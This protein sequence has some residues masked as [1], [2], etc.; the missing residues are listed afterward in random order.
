MANMGTK[1]RQL[2]TVDQRRLL[3]KKIAKMS[4]AQR[5]KLLNLAQPRMVEEYMAHIPHPKQQVF[6]TLRAKE[7]MYGGAA[8][9]GKSDALLMAALQYVDVP[10]YSALI[11]RRTWPDLN[12]PG[13][14]LDRASTWFAGTRAHKR[15]G[16]RIWEFPTFDKEGN[17]A[18]PARISF[19]YMLHDKD[20]HK[21]A[22]AEYQYIGFDEL[23]H[24]DEGQ[25]TFLFSRIRRPDLVCLNCSSA[26]RNYGGPS[27][28]HTSKNV[29]CKEPYPDPKVLAQYPP[30]PDGTSVFDVPL[31]MRSATNPGSTG[32]EWVRDRFVNLVTRK[33]DAVFIPASLAD[34]PSLDY[35]A[36]RENLMH[37]SPVERE[38][39]LN[40][41]W[42]V[43]E[44]G[45]MFERH[46]FKMLRSPTPP[47]SRNVVRFWDN[48]ASAGTG[49]WTVGVKM[50]HTDDGKWVIEDVVRGQWSTLQKQQIMAQTAALD[51]VHVAIRTE[52]EPGSAG[53]DVVD[54]LRRNVLAGYD[55]DGI[56]SSGDKETRAAPFASQAEAGNVYLMEGKWNKDYLDEA[57]QFPVGAHDDQID[58]SS[59]AL[60]YLAFGRRAR[61]LA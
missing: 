50:I 39:L 43:T 21:F 14:I 17:P 28:R 51:G 37:L 11:L 5:A 57:T 12:A 60:S 52:Q 38:R 58:A 31:R 30:A 42:D 3:T 56:R 18:N 9:G 32:H 46:W 19:G 2:T 55:F 15:D 22:S 24:F 33:E 53:V 16:G 10:G 41:D 26:V 35:E 40:G 6:L 29:K 45:S 48:A 4:P 54:N 59:G 36:Y 44:D 7:A 49:D 13:A 61:L 34:N 47:V 25:Y 20:K 23:T 27:F 8:G 1:V